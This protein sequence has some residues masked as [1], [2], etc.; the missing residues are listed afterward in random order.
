MKRP[1]LV[2]NPVGPLPLDWNAAVRLE[3]KQP[4]CDH[5]KINMRMKD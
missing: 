2:R 3:V 4:F 1:N 5:E